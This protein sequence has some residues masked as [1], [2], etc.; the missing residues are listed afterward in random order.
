MLSVLYLLSSISW[1]CLG[2]EHHASRSSPWPWQAC[3]LVSVC[4]WTPPPCP[5][6]PRTPPPPHHSLTLSSLVSRVIAV[7][8]DVAVSLSASASATLPSSPITISNNNRQQSS[9]SSSFPVRFVSSSSLAP[10][11]VC[12]RV[13]LLLLLRPLQFTSG[14]PLWHSTQ[15]HVHCSRDL[16]AT[17]DLPGELQR[18]PSGSV[19]SVSVIC[20]RLS[21]SFS[22]LL[23]FSSALSSLSLSPSLVVHRRTS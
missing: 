21:F 23:S 15:E 3:G 2:D 20:C 4:K 13:F 12:E 10:N 16:F 22:S 1:G 18:L 7:I 8:V 5:S 6:C 11:V 19:S 9:S 14:V 17:G